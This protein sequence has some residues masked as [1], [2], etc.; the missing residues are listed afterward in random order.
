MTI[1]TLLRATGSEA[2]A[3]GGLDLNLLLNVGLFGLLAIVIIFMFRNSRKRRRDQEELQ[4][5]MVPGA[6]VM[7]Q[8]GIFGTLISIDDDTNQAIIETTPGTKLRVHRQVLSR[9]VEP[10]EAVPT[11]DSSTPPARRVQLNEDN[12][13]PAGDPQYGERVDETKPKRAPRKKP[14]E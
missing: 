11:D 9:V 2:A 12:A 1:S 5:K 6:E 3:T 4:T 13:T 8:T 7:T 10:D 14:T